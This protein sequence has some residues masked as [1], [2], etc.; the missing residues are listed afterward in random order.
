MKIYDLDMCD[1]HMD[2]ND[3]ITIDITF[4]FIDW[5]N[6]SQI[7]M[8]MDRTVDNMELVQQIIFKTP[9]TLIINHKEEPDLS[10]TID[11]DKLDIRITEWTIFIYIKN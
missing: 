9:F 1:I 7:E 10:F 4:D 2:D 3:N 5:Y 11:F 8:E 6:Q